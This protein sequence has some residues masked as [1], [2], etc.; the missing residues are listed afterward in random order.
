MFVSENIVPATPPAGTA[1]M[2]MGEPGLPESFAWRDEELLVTR[3][4]RRWKETG[5]C[6]HGSGEQY[7]QKHWFELETAGGRVARV[8]FERKG[9]PPN[10]KKRWWLYSIDE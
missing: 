5:P 2:A 7:V 6:S 9:R 10:F 1:A 8:Y 4:R 3:V